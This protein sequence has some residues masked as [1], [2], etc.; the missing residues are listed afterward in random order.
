MERWLLTWEGK[1]SRID[2]LFWVYF[3]YYC[4]PVCHARCCRGAPASPVCCW[5]P[6]PVSPASPATRIPLAQ[7][8][9]EIPT[10]R[11]LPWPKTVGA[12]GSGFPSP[13]VDASRPRGTAGPPPTAGG[14]SAPSPALQPGP[15][16]YGEEERRLLYPAGGGVWPK[17]QT[18]S[19]R[20]RLGGPS[21]TPA[22]GH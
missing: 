16:E 11:F 5:C 19:L 22:L 7:K 4:P 21:G 13:P 15:S 14:G 2:G 18:M 6:P 12:K 8:G 20:W 1:H 3:W 9:E 17:T 10:T